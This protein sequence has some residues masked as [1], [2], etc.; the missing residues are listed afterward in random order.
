MLEQ[1]REQFNNT[2]AQAT[3]QLNEA[4]NTLDEAMQERIA[5]SITEMAQNLTG[6]TQQLVDDYAPLLQ[7]TNDLISTATQAQNNAH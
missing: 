3:Q 7:A 6:I 1:T 5:S 2:V 4:L